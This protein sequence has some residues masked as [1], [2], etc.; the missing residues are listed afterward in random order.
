MNVLDTIASNPFLKWVV[1]LILLFATLAVGN[2][3]SKA[4]GQIVSLE[5]APSPDKANE[6]IKKLGDQGKMTNAIESI[7][8]DWFFIVAYAITFAFYVFIARE[9][10][11]ENSATIIYQVGTV[12]IFGSFVAG[13]CDVIENLAML[14]MLKDEVAKYPYPVISSLFATTKFLILISAFCYSWIGLL[15]S[16]GKKIS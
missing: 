6:I 16:I 7:R 10:F 2:F 11:K 9:V 5:V 13:V 15:A 1:S 8:R 4:G 14:K 3:V 12:L